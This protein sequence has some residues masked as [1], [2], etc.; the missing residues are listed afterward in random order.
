MDSCVFPPEEP[1]LMQ[2]RCGGFVT[3][4]SRDAPSGP[5]QANIKLF[6]CIFPTWQ[7]T[8]LGFVRVQLSLPLIKW[9]IT[10]SCV[11]H[12]SFSVYVASRRNISTV[13]ATYQCAVSNQAVSSSRCV[14][15]LWYSDYDFSVLRVLLLRLF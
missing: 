5:E 14:C 9:T 8:I 12:P 3:L 7:R 6:Y 15:A 4:T 13:A 11:L 1:R 10:S 2:Q